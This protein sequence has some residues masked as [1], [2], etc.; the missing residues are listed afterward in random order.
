MES[1]NVTQATDN[2]DKDERKHD[3]ENEENVL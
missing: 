1:K 2:P 3:E